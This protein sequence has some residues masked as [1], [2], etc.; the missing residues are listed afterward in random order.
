MSQMIASVNTLAIA[1]SEDGRQILYAR[2]PDGMPI[3]S[4]S[5][6]GD[7][8]WILDHL[9]PGQNS[10]VGRFDWC[11]EVVDG[12]SFADEEFAPLRS[13][14]K[15]FVWS[16]VCER[17]NGLR[18]R[19]GTMPKVACGLVTLVRWMAEVGYSSISEL[20]SDASEDYLEFIQRECRLV[21]QDDSRFSVGVGWSDIDANQEDAEAESESEDGSEGA[22]KDSA[23]TDDSPDEGLGAG[24]FRPRLQVWRHLWDQRHVMSA[25]G[26]DALKEEPFSGRSA[27]GLSEKLG[28]KAAGWIPPVPDEFALPVMREARRWVLEDSVHIIELVNIY[29]TAYDQATKFC[30][31]TRAIKAVTAAMES[32][33][34]AH[35]K[36]RLPWAS[37]DP[38]TSRLTLFQGEIRQSA[39]DP[40]RFVRLLVE[41]LCA[42]CVIVLQSEAGPRSNE[43][44]GLRAKV[45]ESLG[46]GVALKVSKTGLNEHFFLSGLLSKTVSVP[47]EV[48]WLLGS[49]PRGAEEIPVPVRAIQVLQD[50]LQPFRE[51]VRD[52][53]LATC[54]ILSFSS[55]RGVARDGVE[56]SAMTCQRLLKLQRVFVMNNVDLSGLPD[57]NA[58]GQSLAGYRDS[59]GSCLLAHSWRKAFALH[60]F[61]VDQGMIPAIAQQFHHLSLAMTEEGY[62]GSDPTL[63]EVIDSVRHEQTALAL[64]ELVRG[65]RPSAG[66]LVKLIDQFRL[67]F[68]ELFARDGGDPL[69]AVREWVVREDLRI[70]FSSHGKCFIGLNPSASRCHEIGASSHWANIAPNFSHR[71]PEVCIGCPLYAV[72]GDHRQFWANRYNECKRFLSSG[73][74]EGGSRF[75][76]EARMK[77][78]RAVLM[79][80]DGGGDG[81]EAV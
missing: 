42:A 57:M 59:R 55:P 70:W 49:R 54:L 77:Q 74:A 48:E 39:I 63:I 66:R 64:Y 17:S 58:S 30:E 26:S 18:L 29:L 16:L 60:V 67:E 65:A 37:L 72:D 62:V 19:A 56:I 44:C 11:F 47:L 34:Y 73:H 21:I 10:A 2:D 25:F 4:R 24:Y 28:T 15:R 51:R 35:L 31:T 69:D 80:I 36:R 43:V 14:L 41:D 3:S 12:K 22:A 40:H 32:P 38:E 9:T 7:G 53:R 6:F 45:G 79:A 1:S 68:D 76:A 50:V 23:R 75:V 81:K 8:V 46:P 52:S 13:T 61:R 20:T 27:R 5:L 71:T 33:S 78:S